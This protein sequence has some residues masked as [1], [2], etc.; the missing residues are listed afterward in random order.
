MTMAERPEKGNP[1]MAE[2]E[3][4]KKEKSAVQSFVCFFRILKKHSEA[5]HSTWKTWKRTGEKVLCFAQKT[6][7]D[8]TVGSD[9]MD[10]RVNGKPLHQPVE[11]LGG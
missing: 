10:D 9:I 7:S 8:G 2:I 11:L 4:S 1:E 6:E 3:W 5:V